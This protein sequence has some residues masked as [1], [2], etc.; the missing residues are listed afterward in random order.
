MIQRIQTVYMTVAA[1]LLI[2]MLSNPIA[3][4]IISDKLYLTLF[5][6]QIISPDDAMFKPISTW[7]ISALLAV[8]V[9][10]ELF[11]VFLYKKRQVQ[12]RFC[13]LNL[14][15][16]A[17]LVGLIYFFTKYTQSSLNGLKSVFLWPI[18]C[19][20]ISIILNYLAIKAIQKDDNLVKSYDRIR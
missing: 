7:P 15:L 5:H 20:L 6:N 4:I 14:L 8:I 13:I 16:M 19:P 17:G 9:L 12:I 1:F 10:I 3:Q 18:V 2:L 11:V